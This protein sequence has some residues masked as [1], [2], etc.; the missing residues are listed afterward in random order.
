M[1][2]NILK[3]VAG[4]VLLI[5]VIFLIFKSNSEEKPFNKIQFTGNNQI[6]NEKL[7]TYYDT[8][9]NVAMSEVG[10]KGYYVVI[11]DL[12][13]EAKKQNDGELM[14]HVRYHENDFYIFIK[15]LSRTEAI[16]VISHEVIHM[17]Q[18]SSGDL[19]YSDG[20]ITWMGETMP[21]NSKDYSDRPWENDAFKREKQLAKSVESVLYLNK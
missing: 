3:I 21:L 19:S 14:A 13:E 12:S 20:K 8:I 17:L 2:N 9:L 5:I 6:F 10:L 7:P 18:Y 1:K 4:I 16:V 11:S 15:D